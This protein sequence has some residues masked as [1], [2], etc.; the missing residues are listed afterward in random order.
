MREKKKIFVA[1]DDSAILDVMQI[2][3][4]DA[5]YDLLVTGEGEKIEEKI[6]T[7]KPDLILLDIAMGQAHGGRITKRLKSTSS[8]KQ[9]PIII[10][11]ANRDTAKIAQEV[12]AN[13]FLAKPFDMDELLTI[14]KKYIHA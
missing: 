4:E 3:L 14:V 7:Y 9:T 8:T 5:G 6:A 13:G 1:E 2:I 10:I 12:G 11:S